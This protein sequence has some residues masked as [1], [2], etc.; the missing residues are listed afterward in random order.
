M[1]SKAILYRVLQICIA[2]VW[3]I[4]GLYCKVL[5]FVPRHERIVAKVLQLQ[6]AHFITT[7]IGFLE[8]GIAVWILS[9]YKAKLCAA[10]QIA[11]IACMNLLEFFTAKDLLLWRDYNAF[12]AAI[13]IFIVYFTAYK[14]KPSCDT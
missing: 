3:L 4:N 7:A 1:G 13:L 2:L 12:F 8:I 5:N 10:V 14:M 6:D 11:L 9:N